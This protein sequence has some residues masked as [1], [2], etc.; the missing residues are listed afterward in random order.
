MM[1][2]LFPSLCSFTVVINNHIK[3]ICHICVVFMN[4]SNLQGKLL[5]RSHFLLDMVQAC[6]GRLLQ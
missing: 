3:P 4:L 5:V 2:Q 1:Y 6:C